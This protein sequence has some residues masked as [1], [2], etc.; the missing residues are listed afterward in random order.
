[1]NPRYRANLYDRWN[2]FTAGATFVMAVWFYPTQSGFFISFLIGVCLMNM[3]AAWSDN[4][5]YCWNTAME[6]GVPNK[7]LTAT[8][9]I[10]KLI[11]QKK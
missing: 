6:G 7:K 3:V 8:Q 10:N 1:M 5:L 11:T 9:E 2:A 4:L